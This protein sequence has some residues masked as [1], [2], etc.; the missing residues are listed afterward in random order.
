M[1]LN[2]CALKLVT[3]FSESNEVDIEKLSS[4]LDTQLNYDISAIIL[5]GVTGEFSSMSSEEI[6]S[7]VE[8]AT[9][10]I[11]DSKKNISVIV[12]TGVYDTSK[13]VEI[14]IKSKIIGVD[15][16]II[17]TPPSS[18]TN[19]RGI[20]AHYKTICLSS[21]LP[22]FIE[23]NADKNGLKLST[24]QSLTDIKNIVGIIESS[25]DAEQYLRLKLLFGDNFEI[26]VNNDSI[27]LSA[28]SSGATG[29]ISD[30][31]NIKPEEIISIYRLFMENN[32]AEARNTFLTLIPIIDVFKLEPNPLPLKTALN[33]SGIE[34]GHFRLPLAAMEADNAAAIA[35]ILFHNLSDDIEDYI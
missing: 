8:L 30:L 24:L 21:G 32:L 5:G 11:K 18:M 1:I 16:L 2:G 23:N 14:A 9:K 6:I 4:L 35:N 15:G 3:P 22:C 17:S 33:M 19:S 28:L 13:A 10:K 31:I 20:M 29:I 12:H 26:V 7:V 27:F 25:S 34:A